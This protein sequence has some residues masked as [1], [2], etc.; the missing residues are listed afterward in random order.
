MKKTVLSMYMGRGMRSNPCPGRFL[1]GPVFSPQVG[2]YKRKKERFKKKER[3][4]ALTTKQKKQ[5]LDQATVLEKKQV[6][7]LFF[8]L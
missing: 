4:H 5:D 8:R 7:L 3:K 1:S 6:L 2:I